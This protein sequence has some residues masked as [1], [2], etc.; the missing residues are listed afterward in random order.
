MRE[1]SKTLRREKRSSERREQQGK[2]R[3]TRQASKQREERQE[4][5]NEEETDE[6][7]R[8]EEKRTKR[9]E[10]GESSQTK[11][12]RTERSTVPHS[13]FAHVS[14]RRDQQKQ[15]HLRP[16]HLGLPCHTTAINGFGD[17]GI[18]GIG[19]VADYAGVA[20]S[21]V[22]VAAE[23]ELAEPRGAAERH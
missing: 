20:G 21:V 10:R 14:L 3:T 23:G 8:T 7:K 4:E 22:E 19:T 11:E 13:H 15:R 18:E 9:T 17:G 6:E 16:P 12:T 5:T 2:K 1:D